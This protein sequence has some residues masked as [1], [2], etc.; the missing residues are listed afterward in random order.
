LIIV[1]ADPRQYLN[2]LLMTGSYNNYAKRYAGLILCSYMRWHI[3]NTTIK[4][5]RR[6]LKLGPIFLE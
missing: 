4:Y 6:I 3:A 1:A 2:G 5:N